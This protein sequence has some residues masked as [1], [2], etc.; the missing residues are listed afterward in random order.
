M[1]TTSTTP[2]TDRH[3]GRIRALA[4]RRPVLTFCVLAVGIPLFLIG[5]L[6]VAGVSVIPGKA[7]QVV[8]VPALA[9]LITAW[10]SGRAGVRQLFS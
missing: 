6:L 10:S 2:S 7:V 4:I 8:L 9:V 1:T 5:A 3:P